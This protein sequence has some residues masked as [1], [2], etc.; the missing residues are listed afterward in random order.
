MCRPEASERSPRPC[1]IRRGRGLAALL[2]LKDEEEENEGVVVAGGG[3][4]AVRG[5]RGRSVVRRM[6]GVVG[7]ARPC[8][9]NKFD[10]WFEIW[11]TRE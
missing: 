3:R 11:K 6:V 1:Q 2:L 7:G 9:R 10:G 5:R 8:L 4:A